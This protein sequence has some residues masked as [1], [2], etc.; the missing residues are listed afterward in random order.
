MSEVVGWRRCVG[1]GGL[2]FFMYMSPCS[3]S[4]PVR[5]KKKRAVKGNAVSF[6]DFLPRIMF[7]FNGQF[8]LLSDFFW[9]VTS[10]P[11]GKPK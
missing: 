4:Y 3:L 7:Y 10:E 6:A 9:L 1:K 8:F 11:P 5:L 2:I